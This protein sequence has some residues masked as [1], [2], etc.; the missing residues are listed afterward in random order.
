MPPRRHGGPAAACKGTEMIRRRHRYD[1]RALI[2]MD[3]RQRR[4]KARV[5]AK[6][7][8]G[9]YPLETVPCAVCGGQE[10]TTLAEKDAF[11][12]AHRVG[13]CRGCGL[14][15]AQ[16]RTTEDAYRDLYRE[17][18]RC[19][20]HPRTFSMDDYWEDQRTRGRRIVELLREHAARLGP[21]PSGL[22]VLEIGCGPGGILDAFRQV[23]CHVKGTDL[24]EQC[25]RFGRS[26]GLDLECG[27]LSGLKLDSRPD[28][29]LYSHV[30]EHLLRPVEELEATRE[31]MGDES[32]LY[33]EVPGLQVTVSGPVCRFNF[34]RCL[35]IAHV[36]YF[37][38]T[39]LCNLLKV[40]GF[41]PLSATDDVRTVSVKSSSSAGPI[42]NEHDE[43]IAF[44]ETVERRRARYPFT[45]A[46]MFR[47]CRRI[48]GRLLDE[49]GLRGG[50]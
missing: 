21:D 1:G 40:A 50:A 34:L 9:L 14:I 32:L 10:F 22:F 43:I 7:R 5:E 16:P 47:T 8:S 23:G 24:D 36:Y 4:A 39:S 19:L 18:Y 28:I 6:I 48:A 27:T 11:G 25:L 44:L 29:I 46:G 35:E 3:R 20:F 26:K 42:A 33:V 2:R 17:D 45:P 12:F 37:T 38:R 41:R 15:Q 49:L 30:L 31:I 13:A